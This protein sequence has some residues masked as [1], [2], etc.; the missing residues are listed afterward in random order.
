MLFSE[1]IIFLEPI[2]MQANGIIMQV[3]FFK[4]NFDLD[5]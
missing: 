4:Q 2:I 1:K 3:C 5:S